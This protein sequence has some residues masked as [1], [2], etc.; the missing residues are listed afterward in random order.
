[1]SVGFVK[2]LF[3]EFCRQSRELSIVGWNVFF[4][5]VLGFMFNMALYFFITFVKLSSNI[6]LKTFFCAGISDMF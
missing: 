3:C 1:M 2:I 4:W 6:W 5:M